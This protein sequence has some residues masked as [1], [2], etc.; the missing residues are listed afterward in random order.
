[1]PRSLAQTCPLGLMCPSSL[2]HV[3]STCRLPS[4]MPGAKVA[5]MRD[6]VTPKGSSRLQGVG[7]KGGQSYQ[8]SEG[9]SLTHVFTQEVFAKWLPC[10]LKLC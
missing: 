4:P 1:M 10:A 2:L 8:Y 9:R 3:W 7:Q 5:E 6:A